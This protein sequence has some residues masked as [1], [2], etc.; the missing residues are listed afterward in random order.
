MYSFNEKAQLISVIMKISMAVLVAVVINI[1]ISINDAESL[2]A[3]EQTEV[4]M[5]K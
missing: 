1:S 2:E 3:T 4:V 5:S